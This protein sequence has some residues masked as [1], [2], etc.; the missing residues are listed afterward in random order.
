MFQVDG[1]T[2]NG[3][4]A[5]T[6]GKDVRYG[7]DGVNVRPNGSGGTILEATD[8]RTLLQGTFEG[9]GTASGLVRLAPKV[10]DILSVDGSEVTVTSGDAKSRSD[11]DSETRFPP[12]DDVIPARTDAVRSFALQA[13]VLAK[14]VKGIQGVT[15][16]RDAVIRFCIP[17]PAGTGKTPD[18]TVRPIRL[19][20][21]RHDSLAGTRGVNA[22]RSPVRAEG[23]SDATFPTSSDH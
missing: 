23:R 12:V 2:Y 9:N 4:R 6:T 18:G 20:L 14:I 1:K 11:I 22:P 13:D 10:R 17:A 5:I 8:G 3:F 21:P 16:Q 19:E 15:G 7:L